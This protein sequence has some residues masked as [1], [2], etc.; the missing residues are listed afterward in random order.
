MTPPRG[1]IALSGLID[2]DV[3]LL[4]AESLA[5]LE[6]DTPVVIDLG[7]A[8]VAD[9]DIAELIAEG[10]R[11]TVHRLGSVRVIGAPTAI[12]RRLHASVGLTI[13]DSTTSSP[14][15]TPPRDV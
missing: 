2:H 12:R 14:P 6:V 3:A 4:F 15:D 8:S 10:I 5:A 9:A 7:K 11:Q 1:L 13:D